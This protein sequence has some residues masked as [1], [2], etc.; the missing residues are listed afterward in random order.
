MNGAFFAC[1]SM[2]YTCVPGVVAMTSR[3]RSGGDTSCCALEA[4]GLAA[5]ASNVSRVCTTGS[6]D[7][8]SALDGF[9]G[10]FPESLATA[11][12]TGVDRSSRD[13]RVV[14][15]QR[16]AGSCRFF[17]AVFTARAPSFT[18][19]ASDFG[20]ATS[21]GLRFFKALCS[22][23]GEGSGGAAMGWDFL[24]RLLQLH[25]HPLPYPE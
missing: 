2:Q 9:A 21:T 13:A 24:T 4:G 8:C 18:R 23:R 20:P 14:L 7:D 6:G 10:T 1:A 16:R 11:V 22:A 12:F 19:V 17:S 15:T 3:G 5:K 25:L